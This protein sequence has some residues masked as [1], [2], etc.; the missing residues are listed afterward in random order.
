[1]RSSLLRE[2][3][4]E[5][6]E[7]LG[8]GGAAPTSPQALETGQ[9]VWSSG[10]SSLSTQRGCDRSKS[11]PRPLTQPLPS[12][13]TCSALSSGHWVSSLAA[14]P[15][16][17]APSPPTPWAGGCVGMT[18]A[19]PPWPPA[20]ALGQVLSPAHPPPRSCLRRAPPVGSSAS[21]DGCRA[22]QTPGWPG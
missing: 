4:G 9:G 1:M 16:H 11:P 15:P 19:A 7:G 20:T 12:S 10:C 13:V 3:G 21:P 2:G 22:G 17:N 8:V 18:R 14:Q 5:W 6:A